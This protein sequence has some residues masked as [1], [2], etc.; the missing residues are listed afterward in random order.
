M[1]DLQEIRRL[2]VEEKL[3]LMD[4]LWEE[5]AARPELLPV[6][7]E[8]RAELERRL[9]EYQANP[10]EGMTLEEIRAKLGR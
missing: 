9:A 6:D 4:L 2:S 8:T 3:D 7:D 5:L 1:I 10:Q